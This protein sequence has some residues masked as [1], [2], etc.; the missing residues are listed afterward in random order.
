M[1]PLLII[2][3]LLSSFTANAQGI[4]FTSDELRQAADSALK[5]QAAVKRT[6]ELTEAVKDYTTA[7]ELYLDGDYSRDQYVITRLP[8]DLL[9]R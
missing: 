5:G 7:L 4:W 9:Y 8:E 1:K 3:I 2:S 6:A